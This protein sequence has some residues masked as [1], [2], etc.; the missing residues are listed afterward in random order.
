MGA[1]RRKIKMLRNNRPLAERIAMNPSVPE[2][3]D[4]TAEE[5]VARIAMWAKRMGIAVISGAQLKQQLEDQA[6]GGPDFGARALEMAL[7][8]VERKKG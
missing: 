1:G 3:P 5:A 8:E 6:R 7:D 4:E 2:K